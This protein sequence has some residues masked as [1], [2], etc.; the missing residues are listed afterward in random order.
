M[1]FNK[2]LVIGGTGFIGYHLINKLITDNYKIDCILYR[3]K[4][5]IINK[6]IKYIKLDLTNNY[7]IKK[8]LT[9]KY[10]YVINLMGY[11]DHSNSL[12]SSNDNLSTHFFS[13]INIV[14]FFLRNKNIKCFIN[15]GSSDEYGSKK[16]PQNELMRESPETFYSLGKTCATH[17]LQMMNKLFKFPCIILRLFIAYGPY[18]G[19]ERLIPYVIKSCL[20]NKKFYI[21]NK[22]AVRDFCFIDDVINAIIILLK[23]KKC[24]G[25]IFNIGYGKGY[26][27]SKVVKKIKTYCKGG[28]AVFI[29]DILFKKDENRKIANITKIKKFT[30]WRPKVNLNEGLKKTINYYTV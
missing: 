20:K 3:S 27:I 17:Y 2:V 9:K 21:K 25:N 30:N 13:L 6:K 1:K 16:A 14:N 23:S 28:E 12:S 4:E 7:L 15:I 5:K 11:I 22:N 24:Y 19:E 10:D 8:K 29:K 26:K 18:Q